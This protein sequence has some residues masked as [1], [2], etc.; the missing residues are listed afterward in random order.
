VE[1]VAIADGKVQ[2][3]QASATSDSTTGHLDGLH[4]TTLLQGCRLL[5][6]ASQHQA[7][8]FSQQ[9]VSNITEVIEGEARRSSG[10]QPGRQRGRQPP[11]AALERRRPSR[12]RRLRRRPRP[13][14]A[15]RGP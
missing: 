8:S 12:Q 13:R 7:K 15:Q 11:A 9:D 2:Q 5:Y 3:Q 10:G 6:V 4:M 14:A 1:L